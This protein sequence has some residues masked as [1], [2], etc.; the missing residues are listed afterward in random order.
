MLRVSAT[1]RP[2]TPD[3]LDGVAALNSAAFGTPDEAHITRQ[4]H[5]DGDS[6][7]S[8]V[9]EHEDGYLIGHIEFFRILVNGKDV[10]AGLGP[11]SA[12]P[13]HQKR[14]VGY[15]LIK[16]GMPQVEQLGRQLVFVLGH[17]DYYPR[18]GFNPAVAARYDAPW[19]GQAFM[20]IELFET[21][22]RSGTLTYPSA[23]T[24]NA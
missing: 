8:L 11:M 24:D 20:A 21:A 5:A 19:S 22:P 17:P 3:D 14:G 9:A 6:L 18:F 10:A 15:A 13:G 12:A 23:F 2:S 1:I 7:I 16:A 4:L